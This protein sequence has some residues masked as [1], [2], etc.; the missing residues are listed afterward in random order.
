[1]LKTEKKETAKHL[2][3]KL[4]PG[5]LVFFSLCLFSADLT[6]TQRSYLKFLLGKESGIAHYED[7][8]NSF[9]DGTA[10]HKHDVQTWFVPKCFWDR[11]YGIT[12]CNY[13]NK[14][15]MSF[16]FSLDYDG[17]YVYHYVVSLLNECK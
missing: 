2:F 1:M 8:F 5:S 13:E 4:N 12:L 7:N 11:L 9:P 10:F 16:D 14:K 15:E 6:E 3:L 17:C